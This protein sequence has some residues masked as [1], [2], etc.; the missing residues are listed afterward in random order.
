MENRVV[1]DLPSDA[2][3]DDEKANDIV[4]SHNNATTADV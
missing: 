2:D 1:V 3:A 4:G